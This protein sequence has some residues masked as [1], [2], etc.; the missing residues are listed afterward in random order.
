MSAW[1]VFPARFGA[2]YIT[3]CYDQETGTFLHDDATVF[4]KFDDARVEAERRSLADERIYVG[5]AKAFPFCCM[6]KS[7]VS[8]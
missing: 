2:G 1:A 3:S 4:T 8:E 5:V 6:H 7:P